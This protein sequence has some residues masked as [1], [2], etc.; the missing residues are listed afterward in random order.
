MCVAYLTR[1]FAQHAASLGDATKISGC[2]LTLSWAFLLATQ[3]GPVTGLD[4]ERRKDLRKTHPD[5]INNLVRF[6]FTPRTALQ[7]DQ[8]AVKL[9]KC[10][11]YC[12]QLTT[13]MLALLRTRDPALHGAQ[14]TAPLNLD[15]GKKMTFYAQLADFEMFVFF[16]F[17]TACGHLQDLHPGTLET[18]HAESVSRPS[19]QPWGIERRERSRRTALRMQAPRLAR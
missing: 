9:S 12:H 13:P 7:L 18:L 6:L 16:V 17:S 8:I 14:A 15:T 5:L 19:G 10:D 2:A 1:F 11:D 3:R 4:R